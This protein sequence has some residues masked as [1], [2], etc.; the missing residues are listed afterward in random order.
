MPGVAS[1]AGAGALAEPGD[2]APEKPARDGAAT[3]GLAN[4]I[5]RVCSAPMG[6]GTIVGEAVCVFDGVN[7]GAGT[8]FRAAFGDALNSATSAISLEAEA[9]KAFSDAGLG[10]GMLV[11]AGRATGAGGRDG[12]T[13][14]GFAGGAEAAGFAVSGVTG[15]APSFLRRSPRATRNVPFACSTLI[16]LVRTRFAPIRNAFATP[17]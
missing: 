17:T 4:G 6:A 5:S 1:R 14:S 2:V 15:L 9:T 3:S 13:C 8:C 11:A 12:T 10:A 7:K 16:G